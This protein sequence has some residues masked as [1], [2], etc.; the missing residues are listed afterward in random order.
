DWPLALELTSRAIRHLHWAG[1]R[2][3]LAAMFNV[4]ARALVDTNA[5]AAAV[6]QGAAYMFA[7]TPTSGAPA[8][9]APTPSSTSATTTRPR[10]ASFVTLLRRQTTEMLRERLG[11]ERLDELRAEGRTMDSDGAVAYALDAITRE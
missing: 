7:T 3:L 9:P 2:P 1:E 10:A 5:E 8:P 11:Q 6:I 4:S